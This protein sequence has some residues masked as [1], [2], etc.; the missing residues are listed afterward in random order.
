MTGESSADN[1]KHSLGPGARRVRYA[2]CALSIVSVMAVAAVPFALLNR[3]LALLGQG[4]DEA[5]HTLLRFS[6]LMGISLLFLQMAAGAFRPAL[7]RVWS[8]KAFQRF[9]TGVGL[10]GLTFIVCHFAFL[11]PSIGE[12]WASLNHGFFLLGPAILFVLMVT[13]ATALARRRLQP[14]IWAR[15]HVLNYLVLTVGIVHALG[16]GTEATMFATWVIFVVFLMVELIGFLFRASFPE[17]RGRFK[18]SAVR[19]RNSR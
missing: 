19:A 17:W 2:P 11:V 3:H 4:T 12:H 16:I 5:L 13:I 7:R 8:Q 9:H 10:A 6:A 14:G 1:A 18:P 15:L